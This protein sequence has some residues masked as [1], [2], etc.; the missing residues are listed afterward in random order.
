MKL[1]TSVDRT[2]TVDDEIGFQL[3]V[4]V[5]LTPEEKSLIQRYHAERWM[6]L[7]RDSLIYT[8]YAANTDIT[9]HALVRGTTFTGGTISEILAYEQRVKEAF[10]DL[11]DVVDLI[12]KFGKP[13]SNEDAGA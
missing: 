10:A 11:E 8:P 2:I 4:K 5:E 9:I 13:A 6:L 3:H 7:A 12:R 1:F